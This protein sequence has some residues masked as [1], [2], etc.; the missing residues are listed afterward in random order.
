M[1][2]DRLLLEV[3]SELVQLYPRAGASIIHEH[4]EESVE[5]E[6]GPSVE[7]LNLPE[8]LRRT[9]IKAGISR[10]YKFQYEAFE[11]ILNGFN[12]VVVAG[13]GTGK[14]EA[15]LIPILVDVHRNPSPLPRAVV[16][17][18]TKALSR[19]QLARLHKY[20]VFGK[21]SAGVYD[22]D[23]PVE[24]RRRMRSQPPAVL[25]TNPDMIH[26]G[27]VRSP[28]I[29]SFVDRAKFF[30]VDEL[31]VYEGVLGTHLKYIVDRVKLAKG[32]QLQFIASSGTLSNPKEFAESIFGVDVVV[33]KGP[34]RRRGGAVHA[35]VSTGYLSR[36]TIAA[37]LSS[38][39]AKRGLKHI[40]FVDSQQMA[41][42]V[43]RIGRSFGAEVV[44]HRAGLPPEERRR[45]EEKLKSG[46]VL[47]VAAT[48]TLELGIDIGDLDAVVMSSPPPSF[49]KYVQ[50]AGRAG[51]RGRPGYVFTILADDPIDSY[52]ERYPTQFFSQEIPPSVIEPSNIEV[53]KLHLLAH[54]L[55]RGRVHL[56]SLP[57]V[58]RRAV[59]LLIEHG[60]AY[61]RGYYAYPRRRLAMGFLEEYS[62]IRSGGPLVEIYD[63]ATGEVL[64]SRELPQALLDL[65][66]GAIYFIQTKPYISLGVDIGKR[67][68]Y[69]K[70]LDED[71]NYYTK[72]LY[73]VD[74]V[75]FEV[76]D[77]R[78]SKRN[79]PLT[80]ANVEL[81]I[82]VEGYV[83]KNAFDDR[84][85]EKY[86]LDTPLRYPYPTKAVLVKYPTIEEW[87]R[88]GH[89]E[90]FHAIE[91]SLIS[92]A[93][94]VCGAGLTDMGGVSY[95]SGDIVI[96]DAA[97]GGSGL[98]RLLFERFERA[99]E[100]AHDIV[101]SCNCEDGCPRCIYSPFCG[102]NN[103]VL[104]RR[105]AA[106]YLNGLLAG[107]L[108]EHGRPLE[109]RYGKPI[110]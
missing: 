63:E 90:A 26:V 3:N 55:E 79:I 64:G 56:N 61:T 82:A 7:E 5:P 51:R 18:P 42:L 76:L 77:E 60:L 50:R 28:A 100:I 27:L 104:S 30:V 48:P 24:A 67:A 101:S 2:R 86:W 17:Y 16:T 12:T 110:A 103:Q 47:A 87:D 70:R 32:G 96:Y 15:F 75:D 38:I 68:A 19:D 6:L 98:A 69:V 89:A 21:V 39:L 33:V 46:E 105:K 107:K 74:V 31:H 10:L 36:W 49:T 106:Y 57:P 43:A 52:Y 91:H 1:I 72:P 97:P 95:P 8:D 81:E 93:R 41:E 78:V 83:V 88:L 66:P 109:A 34:S 23:T 4:V 92:A 25:I 71:V 45:V 13:T 58:W 80:Y 11:N 54:L 62:S 44:V 84:G 85:G 108:V 40:V 14:T 73:T 99:E 59:E 35:L 22:G 102:N 20:L 29:R 37:A 65:Y 53:A 9:L 94:I